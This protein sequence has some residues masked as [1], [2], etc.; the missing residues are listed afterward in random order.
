MV[1]PKD[2]TTIRGLYKEER[3]I[4]TSSGSLVHRTATM[5]KPQRIEM[6]GGKCVIGA[7]VIIRGDLASVE[8]NRYSVV[9]DNSV[10]RPS[11]ILTAKGESSAFRFIPLTIGKYSF[12]G[13]EC[14]IECAAIGVGCYVGDGAIL[15]KGAI[16]KDYVHV[17]P[18]TIV[19]PD[20]VVPPFSVVSGCPARFIREQPH[21]LPDVKERN[22]FSR[23]STF[24]K[25]REG[26]DD[27]EE[28][29]PYSPPIH[30]P[31]QSAPQ[32]IQEE[33]ASSI[34][35]PLSPSPCPSSLSPPTASE[36]PP[37]PCAPSEPT[38]PVDE[39]EEDIPP[40]ATQDEKKEPTV[41]VRRSA[42]LR[43]TT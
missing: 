42:R 26:D 2:E 31:A 28:Q 24:L 37:P 13:R 29:G 20:L 23:Y 9:R 10:L 21:C 30:S 34:S 33:P 6:P 12:I 35:L 41:Q 19:P 4:K 3:Y 36:P 25:R 38:P 22:A 18:G 11:G 15:C 14:V 32:R 16:L 7:G 39:D 17:S 5:C 27:A 40:D 8:L 1:L 43:K